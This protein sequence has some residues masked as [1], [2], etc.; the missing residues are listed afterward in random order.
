MI[1]QPKKFILAVALA[2]A[3]A[4]GTTLVAGLAGAP[5]AMAGAKVSNSPTNAAVKKTANTVANNVVANWGAQRS[6]GTSM[7]SLREVFPPL[8]RK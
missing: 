7:G 3:G 4:M 5:A 2:A 8:S 6:I 1:I